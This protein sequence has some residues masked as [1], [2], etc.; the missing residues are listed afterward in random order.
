MR[1]QHD[2]SQTPF[3]PG[4]G[5]A[6]FPGPFAAL[7]LTLAAIFATAFVVALF[8]GQ[9][10][11]TG[12]GVGEAVG[13]GGVATLAARRVPEPQ[14]ERLGLRTF[15]LNL[16]APLLCLLPVVIL[17]SELDNWVRILLPPSPELLELV[18][19]AQSQ[20]KVLSESGSF[21]AAIQ[22]GIVA[23][24]ISPLVESFLFFGVIL[25]GVVAHI[26]RRRGILLT[27]ILYSLLH[28]PAAPA[29][30]D[31]VV[32]MASALIVAGLLCL[33]RLASGSLLAPALLAAA[34][35]AI[36]LSAVPL[37]DAAPIPGFNAEGTH[38]PL[39]ILLPSAAA[40]LWGFSTLLRV[41]RQQPLAP[42]LPSPEHDD[43]D[44]GFHF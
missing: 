24:G 9:P 7:L 26:G 2:T 18:A 28:I 39:S 25:Q 8:A 19:E 20:A 30:G 38:T 33:A 14:A 4:S 23:L 6:I 36:N 32:P 42:P 34:L 40:L 37:A 22:T 13:L 10:L 3:F 21:Y 44:E 41:A 43:P 12:L 1:K 11:I 17:V 29:P 5:S 35:A 15:D 31:A 16:L 27:A